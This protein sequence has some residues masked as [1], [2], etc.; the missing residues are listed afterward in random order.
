MQYTDDKWL[1]EP[2]KYYPEPKTLL[3]VMKWHCAIMELYSKAYH[4]INEDKYDDLGVACL[5]DLVTSPEV[6]ALFDRDEKYM[7]SLGYDNIKRIEAAM[8][9]GREMFYT[10]RCGFSEYD[11]EMEKYSLRDL[12]KW[13][14]VFEVP[15]SIAEG[16]DL[17][18][19]TEYTLS[20]KP[21]FLQTYIKAVES[22]TA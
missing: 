12:D 2:H 10:K 18:L 21:I 19:A 22:V 15:L 3:N 6:D 16:G 4:E 9:I 14:E 5:S 11:E 17:G 20:K 8:L 13:C 7:L 1:K